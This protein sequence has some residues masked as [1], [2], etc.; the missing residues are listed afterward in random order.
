MG[1]LDFWTIV[2]AGAFSLSA[3]LILAGLGEIFLQRSGGFN[4]GIEG[5]MLVGAVFGVIGSIA[6]G[7]W[8]GLASGAVVGVVL[9][10]LFGAA[11][12]WG[13]AH[14]VIVG[15]AVGLAGGGLSTA[16]YQVLAPSGS[17]NQI[18]P[19]QP[20]V[21]VPLLSDVPLIGRGLANAGLLF[22]ASVM[23][24]AL[25]SWVLYRTRFGLRLRAV[26][27]DEPV[28]VTRGVSPRRIRV[29]AATIA[30]ALAGLGGAAVPLSAIG[31]FTPGMT[32]GAG[33]IA[34]AVV[35]IARRRPWGLLAG[36][37]FFSAFNSLAL[38]AQTRNLGLPV[39]LY[40]AMPYLATLVVLCVAS[41]QR[42]IRPRAVAV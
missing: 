17:D 30:G 5:M 6:G 1:V 22:Y 26:G 32:G 15:I 9:G 2:V 14:I 34:L 37:L 18:A 33:F 16:L 7:F 25:G 28:A 11:V 21:A 10:A 38:L 36:A 19:T 40:Q 3:P 39:E 42:T 27:A 12:A 23:L 13:R 35:S 41:R 4:V 31:T 24:V 8:V 29:I 20:V